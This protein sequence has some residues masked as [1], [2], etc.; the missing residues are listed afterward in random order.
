MPDMD[1]GTVEAIATLTRAGTAIRNVEIA[2]RQFS[3]RPLHRVPLDPDTPKA[4]SFYTL[5]A[6]AAYLK[7]DPA[8]AGMLVHV[9]T[10]TRVEAVGTLEGADKHI[11]RTLAVAEC[12]LGNPLGFSFNTPAPMDTLNIALQ[13]C[14][15]PKGDVDD[16]RKFCASVKSTE[17]LGLAD[18]G[19]S[20][21]VQAKSGIAAVLDTKVRNPW[22]L[23]PWRTFPE[24]DQPLSPYVLRF[25][26]D[27]DPRGGL[28]ETGN[29]H[30][31][32]EA[33]ANIAAWLRGALVGW[34]V[35]G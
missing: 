19:V 6:F 17:E 28:Y 26:K 34:N 16:L 8:A 22:Q 4:L 7:A 21:Q 10:P 3:E 14:F 2:G 33:V 23:A 27:G 15:A 29:A 5:A 12:Q 35:L 13:T 11:R 20:Q 25:V 31:R 1:A 32:T 30:W 24:I 18:D 9:V